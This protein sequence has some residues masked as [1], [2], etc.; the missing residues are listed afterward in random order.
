[1]SENNGAGELLT[2]DQVKAK[3]RRTVALPSG[4]SVVVGRISIECLTAVIGGMPDVS[5]LAAAAEDEAKATAAMKR[6]EARA[7]LKKMAAAIVEGVIEPRLFEDRKDGPSV[8]D[9]SFEDQ[10][11]LFRN[12]LELSS[13]TKEVGG[14]VLPLSK[15]V[16]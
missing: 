7:T 15:T 6:P 5:A 2:P 3:G 12:I 10:A 8:H 11:V 9:F 4:G 14:E 13:F 1:M 16:V